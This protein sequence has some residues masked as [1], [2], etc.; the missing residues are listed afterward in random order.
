MPDSLAL[1]KSSDYINDRSMIYDDIN[2][3]F[4]ARLH[5]ITNRFQKFAYNTNQDTIIIGGKEKK[6]LLHLIASLTIMGPEIAFPI[7]VQP[8][9]VT[10]KYQF[11]KPANSTASVL[12]LADNSGEGKRQMPR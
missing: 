4:F 6:K 3:S 11:W 5:T 1:R 9:Q 7:N 12:I 8:V 10:I 2:L